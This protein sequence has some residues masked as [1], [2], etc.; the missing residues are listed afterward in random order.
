MRVLVW[1]AAATALFGQAAID[2]STAGYGGGGVPLPA[3]AAAVSVRPSGGDDTALL[4]G[5]LDRVAGMRVRG[6]G[7]S[8][9]GAAAAR[10]VPRFGAA[11]DAGFGRGAAGE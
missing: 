7:I 6:L 3:V 10:A 8:R 9:G 1:L 2:F 11:A 5:A 4:Q